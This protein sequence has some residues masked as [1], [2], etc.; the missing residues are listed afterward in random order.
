MSPPKTWIP[1]RAWYEL[2]CLLTGADCGDD[3]SAWE[4][5][6][7]AHPNLVWDEKLNRLVDTP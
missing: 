6:F 1:R 3:P 5:W 4:A 2:L 7:H